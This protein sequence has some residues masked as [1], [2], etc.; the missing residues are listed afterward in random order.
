M[1]SS[2]DPIHI[3]GNAM[4]ASKGSEVATFSGGAR[5]WRAADIIEAPTIILDRARRALQANG[6]QSTQVRTVFVQPDKNRKTTPVNITADK[7]NYVDAELKAVFSRNVLVRSADTT[8]NADLIQ[9]L[10]KS[11][12]NQPSESATQLD[13]IVANGEIQIEQKGRK[14]TGNQLVYTAQDQKFV[15]TASEGK[16]P[17][18][19]DAEHEPGSET[20]ARSKCR[21]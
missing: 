8:M 21:P 20:R 12:G 5:L 18:I 11:R 14:A 9:V 15:L 17:S 6:N 19:F 3:T 13:H 16:R 4:T 1:L 7:L 2:S 10:L